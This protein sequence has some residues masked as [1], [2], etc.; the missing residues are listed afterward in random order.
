MP[1]IFHTNRYFSLINATPKN[2]VFCQSFSPSSSKPIPISSQYTTDYSAHMDTNGKLYV[3][4]MPDAFHLNYYIYEGNRFAR[5]SLISNANSNFILTSPIIYTLQNTPYIVYLSH[6]AESTSYNF[7]QEN[8][9]NPQLI[10][11]LTCHTQP[12]LIKSYITPYQLFVFFI[13][14]DEGYHLN[15]LQISETQVT[16]SVYLNSPQPISD[17]SVCIEEDTLHITYISELHGKYQLSYFNNY[18]NQITPLV[19]TQYPCYPVIFCYYN[20]IWINALINHK[21]QMIISI[22]NGKTFSLPAPCSIQNNIHRCYFLTH[23]TSPFIGQ[24]IYASITSYLK[25]CTLSMIDFPR[26]HTD[27]V[28]SSELELLLE[29]LLL[30]IE[31]ASSSTQILVPK[32]EPPIS[33]PTKPSSSES[34]TSGHT[35]SDAKSAFMNELTGWDLPPRL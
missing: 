14:H 23:T 11:L 21:L 34:T 3:A 7:V 15:V 17:Y 6:Q 20:I 2:G 12:S 27:T 13:T 9:Y 19:T 22:D 18:S 28:I 4:V 1:Y 10:T 35:I 33:Q 32:T 25:L 8:L 5:N 24:E 29:G 30:T 26:F 16:S 31:S